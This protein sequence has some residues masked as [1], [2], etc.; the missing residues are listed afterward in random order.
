[1]R[2]DPR[3]I[4]RRLNPTCTKA[5]EAMVERAAAGRHYEIVVEHLLIGLVEIEDGDV[6][7]L[8]QHFRKDRNKLVAQIER[9]LQA[10]RTGNQGKPVFSETLFNWLENTWVVAS[11]ER[12][13]VQ[14][15]SGD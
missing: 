15:R 13:S 11:L 9:S 2:V 1:M 4:V 12:G 8:L 3:A 6:A 14:L 10:M 7:H 5:L